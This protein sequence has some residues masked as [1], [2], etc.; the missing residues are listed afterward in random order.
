[1]VRHLPLESK[2]HRGRAL[3]QKLAR[4]HHK[5]GVG[6]SDSGCELPERTSITRVRVRP[7]ENL[8][9]NKSTRKRSPSKMFK[10]IATENYLIPQYVGGLLP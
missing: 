7:E 9:V 8:S 1:M 2:L 4:A 5:G 6:I 10:T 3:D